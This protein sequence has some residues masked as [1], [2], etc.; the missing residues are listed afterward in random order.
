MM[1]TPF[2]TD[3]PFSSGWSFAPRPPPRRVF[4]TRRCMFSRGL[5]GASRLR[6]AS[7]SGAKP[8]SGT[9]WAA[10]T[11]A[12]PPRWS[13]WLT[14]SSARRRCRHWQS[15]TQKG[16]TPMRQTSATLLPTTGS[17]KVQGLQILGDPHPRSGF[18]SAC[19]MQRPEATATLLLEV[20]H[21][22]G[23]AALRDYA[24]RHRD[25][26]LLPPACFADLGDTLDPTVRKKRRR[27]GQ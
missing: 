10:T 17:R 12:E 3:H 14:L 25:R 8:C 18:L 11:T 21:K 22:P 6:G 23:T 4:R 24:L 19:R 2:L 16:A 27:T 5:L 15:H 1:L 7:G 20:L 9:S 26:L 13:S